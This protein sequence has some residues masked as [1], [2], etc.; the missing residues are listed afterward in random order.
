MPC[1]YC[2]QT[3]RPRPRYAA[4]RISLIIDHD[5]WLNSVH[6]YRNTHT[7]SMDSI[8]RDIRFTHSIVLIF[9]NYRTTTT[10]KQKKHKK[11]SLFC[12]YSMY[13]TMLLSIKSV[14][15]V[16]IRKTVSNHLIECMAL[17]IYFRAYNIIFIIHWNLSPPLL[18]CVFV[19]L[20]IQSI[21]SL[22]FDC[23]GL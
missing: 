9:A 8:R 14:C 12:L 21:R 19:S 7:H 17:C 3:E 10:T 11:R 13:R 20:S 23:I 22:G 6:K 1:E 4:V 16:F 5:G 2:K 15:F 18:R